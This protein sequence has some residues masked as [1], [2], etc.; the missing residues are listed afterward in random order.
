MLMNEDFNKYYDWESHQILWDV[1][2]SRLNSL[3]QKLGYSSKIINL[4]Q[5]CLDRD[6]FSRVGVN[7]L[8]GLLQSE[9]NGMQ[10]DS[11]SKMDLRRSTIDNFELYSQV[12]ARS[13]RNS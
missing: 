9:G 4:V 3:G 12:D 10:F 13:A 6:E 5:R 2:R 8:H 11:P 1:I 7:E